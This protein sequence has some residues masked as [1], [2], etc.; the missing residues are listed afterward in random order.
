MKLTTKDKELSVAKNVI[1]QLRDQAR[2]GDEE[3]AGL[4]Q[5]LNEVNYVY[6]T[7]NF[8]FRTFWLVLEIRWI[9]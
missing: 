2:M 4:Q 7:R 5:S 8:C 3:R 6:P 1:N 9:K